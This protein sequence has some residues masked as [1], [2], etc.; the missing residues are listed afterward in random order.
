MAKEQ[1]IHADSGEVVYF[2]LEESFFSIRTTDNC[3]WSHGLSAT[4]FRAILILAQVMNKSGGIAMNT[5]NKRKILK[6]LNVKDRSYYAVMKKLIE[7]D[8]I[9]KVENDAFLM[10]PDVCYRF[11]SNLYDHHKDRY[12]KIKHE[13]SERE[14]DKRIKKTSD[15]LNK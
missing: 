14:F 4:D 6:F 8:I 12:E 13:T 2:S 3:D 1:Y 15:N 11:R 5:L 7:K 9:I 10:N